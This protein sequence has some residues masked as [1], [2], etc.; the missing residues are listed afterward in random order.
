MILLLFQITALHSLHFL[1]KGCQNKEIL[2][3]LP[4][5]LLLVTSS[6]Y[7]LACTMYL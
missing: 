3:N 6:D 2:G 4:N 7:Q 5:S 1:K